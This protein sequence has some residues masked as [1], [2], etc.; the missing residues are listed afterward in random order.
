MDVNIGDTVPDVDVDAE[1]AEVLVA[2]LEVS[3]DVDGVSAGIIAIDSCGADSGV[4]DGGGCVDGRER[5]DGMMVG[6]SR[7]CRM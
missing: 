5:A 1:Y 4:G 2:I 3:T 6:A 7:L